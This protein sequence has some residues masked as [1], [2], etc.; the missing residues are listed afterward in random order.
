MAL[1][2]TV[3][4]SADHAAITARAGL[5][6]MVGQGLTVGRHYVSVPLTAAA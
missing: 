4:V 6:Y 2:P 3:I 1:A 5:G